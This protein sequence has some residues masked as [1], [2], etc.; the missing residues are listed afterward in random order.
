MKKSLSLC[1]FVMMAF[2]ACKKNDT[3][4]NEP[5]KT[6]SLPS[7]IAADV[8]LD[9]SKDYIIDGRVTV[10]NNASLTIPAGVTVSVVK[11]DQAAE[12][13]LLLVTRGSKLFIN[14]TADHPVVFTSAATAPAP[15]DWI[16]ILVLG[17]ATINVPGGTDHIAGLDPTADTEYGG[18]VADDNSGSINYLRVEYPGGLNPENEDEWAVDKASGFVLGGVGSGTNVENVM[19]EYSYDDAFQFVGGSVNTT[20]LIAYNNGDDDFDFDLGYTGNLQFLISYRSQF[21][22]THALRANGMESYNDEVP[23]TNPPLT[24]PIISNMTIVGPEGNNAT[25]TNLNQGVYIRKGT[26]FVMQNSVI[27]EYPQG[28]LMV[29]PRTKPPLMKGEGSF[30]KY[31]L[32]HSDDPNRTF[33]YDNAVTVNGDPELQAFGLNSDN[34]NEMFLSSADLKLANIYAAAGPDL[35]PAADSPA[36]SGANFDGPNYATFFTPVTFRGAVGPQNWAAAS[37]WAVWK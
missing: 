15:G 21:N 18:T 7:T 27:A 23:T 34:K 36:A 14:G 33:S 5:R 35:T 1:L 22:S 31:N 8:T 2:A 29:C 3:M 9:A 10:K 37:N 24:R 17:N 25:K 4:D 16:G 13:G 11:H 32:V 30:F 20:H 6:E 28:A 19:V 26:R 12:K